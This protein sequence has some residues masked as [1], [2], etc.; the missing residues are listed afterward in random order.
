MSA[1]ENRIIRGRILI[2]LYVGQGV[3]GRLTYTDE[4]LLKVLHS[5]GYPDVTLAQFHGFLN[6]LKEKGYVE[7]V[8]REDELSL[9]Y[10]HEVK[11]APLGV[12]LV[13]GSVTDPGVV[14]SK[15]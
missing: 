10:T 11:L 6:Y 8:V 13:E 3:E 14:I 1:T 4:T 5:S 12:D 7:T 9:M 15:H 2:M